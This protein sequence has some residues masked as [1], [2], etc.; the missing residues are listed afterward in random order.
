MVKVLDFIFAARPMLLLPVWS[1]YL[2]AYNFYF[3]TDS[4][5]WYNIIALICLTFLVAG[6]YYINQIYDYQSDLINKKL[7]FL[8]SGKISKNEMIVVYVAISVIAI[9]TGFRLSIFLGAVFCSVFILGYFYSA[10]PLRLK[11]R[12]ILGLLSNSFAYGILVPL[13]IPGFAEKTDY[14]IMILPI[15]YFMIVSAGYLLTVLPDREGDAK[16]GK[17]TLAVILSDRSIIIVATFLLLFSL[18]LAWEMNHL[19]LIIISSASTLLYTVSL[20]IP[21]RELILLACKLP[22]LLISLL[23]GYYYPGYFVFL[24]ALLFLTRLY[25]KKRFGMV[26]PR[27]N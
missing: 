8:Q 20:I 11:D 16:T 3:G 26:Y 17:K 23:A 2:I 13:S 14:L 4:F 27:I 25:Y 18:L 7:G 1:L 6:A 10:P 5:D 9:I 15:Y 21:K 22:I 19:F 12:P 24:L